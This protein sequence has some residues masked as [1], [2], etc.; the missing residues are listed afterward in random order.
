MGKSA[1]E[2]KNGTEN[3][4]Q[5]IENSIY[6]TEAKMAD[7]ITEIQHRLSPEHLKDEAISKV[8]EYAGRG[9]EKFQGTV[10]KAPVPFIAAAAGMTF[11]LLR[12]RKKQNRPEQEEGIT[13]TIKEKAQAMLHHAAPAMADAGEPG[14][15]PPEMGIRQQS[16]AAEPMT[17]TPKAATGRVAAMADEH[18]L[19]LGVAGLVVGVILG[20]VIPVSRRER[21]VVSQAREAL[22]ERA[23][24][25][26]RETMQRVQEM[27]GTAGAGA[28]AQ[29]E[30]MIK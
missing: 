30:P 24:Q 10:K 14:M 29:T 28:R 2:M 16:L 21:E 11:F 5:E 6:R 3:R 9:M 4:A 15:R 12:R 7:T 8:K 17:K 18:P 20:S 25:A 1:D 22:I 13:N 19:M 26:G 23:K 27:A